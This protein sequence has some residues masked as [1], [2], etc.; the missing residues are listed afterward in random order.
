MYDQVDRDLSIGEL[1]R[2]QHFF[3]VLNIDV[4]KDG[5]AEQAHGLLPVNQSYHPTVPFPFEFFQQLN[6]LPFERP[7]RE[8]WLK[9]RQDEIDPE[10]V[11]YAHR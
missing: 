2:P 3:R 10:N 4:T 11:D 8:P 6:A 5:K 9:R 7:L 1:D